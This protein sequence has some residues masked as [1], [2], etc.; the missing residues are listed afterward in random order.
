MIIITAAPQFCVVGKLLE[1]ADVPSEDFYYIFCHGKDANVDVK[2]S[3]NALNR[4]PRD[5]EEEAWID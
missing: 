3:V 5:E 2:G 1:N 4:D